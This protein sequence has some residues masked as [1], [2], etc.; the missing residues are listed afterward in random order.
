M[1]EPTAAPVPCARAFLHA[2]VW[3]EH[4]AVWDLLSEAGRTTVLSV[5]VGQGLDRVVA[6]R[7]RDGL[8][9]PADRDDFLRRLLEGLRRDLRSVELGKLTVDPV[10]TPA[11]AGRVVVEMQVPSE[12]PGTGPWPAGWIVLGR[13]TA[14]GW[15]V[16][17]LEP[18]LV[19]P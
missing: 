4:T 17:R 7:M 12:I 6:R 8:A 9:D 19:T 18:R 10:A 2:I 13:D 15:G 14:G 3:G 1:S 11:E 5:A 16:D